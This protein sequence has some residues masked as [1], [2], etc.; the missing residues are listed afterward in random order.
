MDYVRQRVGDAA[1]FSKTVTVGDVY[2]YA[3][4]TRDLNPFHVNEVYVTSTILKRRIKH[5][6]LLG[7]LISNAVGNELPGS[8]AESLDNTKK[9]RDARKALARIKTVLRE[10]Q[11]AA[12]REQGKS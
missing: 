11:L 1:E 7:S 9:I 10:R 2:L 5:R 8:R 6:V 3:G 12:T 4:I